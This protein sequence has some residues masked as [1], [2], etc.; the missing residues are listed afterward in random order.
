[1]NMMPVYKTKLKWRKP[2]KKVIRFWPNESRERERELA[3]IT[4]TG[5]CFMKCQ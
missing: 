2:E 4:Q 1:M 3:L 5:K